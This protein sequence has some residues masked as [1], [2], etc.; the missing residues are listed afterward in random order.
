MDETH[1]NRYDI[2]TAR[3]VA[4]LP[5]LIAWTQTMLKPA[6]FWLLWKGTDWRKEADLAELSLKLVEERPLN[7]GGVLIKLERL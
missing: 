4:P 7:D 3:A 2:I 5:A 1:V 6:G